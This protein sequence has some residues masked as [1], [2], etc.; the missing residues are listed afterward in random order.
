MAATKSKAFMKRNI[1]EAGNDEI[2]CLLVMENNSTDKEWR[3]I[4]TKCC[5]E[6][7]LDSLN[8]ER[9]MPLNSIKCEKKHY[10]SRG[11][12]IW[13]V[14]LARE[15]W[16]RNEA[17]AEIIKR[18]GNSVMAKFRENC[19]NLNGMR[20][21]YQNLENASWH[22]LL[23]EMMSSRGALASTSQNRKIHH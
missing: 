4:C 20:R 19:S 12:A 10:L 22:Q 11:A 8:R 6:R 16:K 14:R 7:N 13:N 23:L 15:E 17:E 2:K 18:E 1:G 3:E 9:H 21:K 5:R